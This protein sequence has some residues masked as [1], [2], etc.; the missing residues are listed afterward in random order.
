MID[1]LLYDEWNQYYIYYYYYVSKCK[2]EVNWIFWT[3]LGVCKKNIA[4]QNVDL[5]MKHFAAQ[6]TGSNKEMY[7]DITKYFDTKL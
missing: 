7:N 4:K 6:G 5:K 1:I 2:I 3:H